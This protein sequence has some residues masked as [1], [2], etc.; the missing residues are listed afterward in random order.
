MFRLNKILSIQ[1]NF[2]LEIVWLISVFRPQNF[3]STKYLVQKGILS[4]KIFGPKKDVDT[5]KFWVKWIKVYKKFGPQKFVDPKN[6]AQKGLS[7]LGH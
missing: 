6:V 3:W 7:K 4:E 1:K 2:I 5:I